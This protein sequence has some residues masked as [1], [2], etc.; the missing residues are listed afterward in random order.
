MTPRPS[1]SGRAAPGRADNRSVSLLPRRAGSTTRRAPGA[2]GLSTLEAVLTLLLVAV[3][4]AVV[5]PFLLLGRRRQ[6]DPGD[7]GTSAL[8]A[9]SAAEEALTHE[10]TEAPAP[11]LDGTPPVVVDVVVDPGP[12]EGLERVRL[13]A[14]RPR[15]GAEALP[16]SSRRVRLTVLRFVP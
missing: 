11:R 8:C 5:V 15:G 10:P 13:T 3:F 16:G 12:R 7:D 1:L 9:E 14:T 4:A 2:R 6:A